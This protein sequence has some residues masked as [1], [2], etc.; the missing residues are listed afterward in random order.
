VVVVLQVL[1]AQVVLVVQ[2]VVVR[3]VIKQAALEIHLQLRHHK[4]IM[5]VPLTQTVLIKQA[6]VAAQ[7][8]L[9]DKVVATAVTAVLVFHLQ[10]QEQV[11]PVQ[12]AVVVEVTSST[13]ALAEEPQQQVAVK[14]A[15]TLHHL[16]L[17]ELQIL[18]EAAEALATMVVT[19]LEESVALA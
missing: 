18:V 5:V 9:V 14:V 3:L 7:V 11:L 2:V 19:V 16:V 13:K 15:E 4:E 1:A 17:Q 10:L 8:V 6:A 12:V